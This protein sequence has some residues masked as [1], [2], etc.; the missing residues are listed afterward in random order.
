MARSYSILIPIGILVLAWSTSSTP[1]APSLEDQLQQL[2]KD[3]V[4]FKEVT[5]EKEATFEAE[6]IELKAKDQQNS[7]IIE[8][9]A[10]EINELKE[11]VS[12][13]E[14][15][16]HQQNPHNRVATSSFDS[17]PTGFDESK[18]Q[19]RSINGMPSS[20]G[21]L[22]MIG[23]SWNGLYSIMGLRAVE[24]VYC[25]FNK[26][27]DDPGFQTRI[28]YQDIKTKPIYFYVQK[29]RSFATENIPMPFELAMLNSGEA[30]NLETGIFTAPVTGTYFFSF[31]A[32][33]QFSVSNEPLRTVNVMLYR[34]GQPVARSQ[35][36]E[37]NG[38]ANSEYLSPL[39]LQT[40]LALQVGD[41]V[42]VQ[43]DLIDGGFLYDNNDVGY[44]RCTHF[45]GWLLEE[46]I[47]PSL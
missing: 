13:L 30:M 4:Q 41:E 10:N 12:G 40:A 37:V 5:N 23:H 32:L 36:N 31:T 15:Q 27:L 22:Q 26:P 2:R 43:S 28:G 42:W 7:K 29:T 46:E 20:C 8:S 6:L 14:A 16:L 45:N 9:L 39:V 38:I 33:A 35:L 18:H 24:T 44:A 34:N 25:D 3:F 11:K 19:P 1:T 47:A 21:D 17:S